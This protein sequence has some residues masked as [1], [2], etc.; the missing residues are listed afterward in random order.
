MVSSSV[1]RVN[2]ITFAYDMCPFHSNAFRCTLSIL[3]WDMRHT[4]RR[5]RQGPFVEQTLPNIRALGATRTR[6][7][8]ELRKQ[9]ACFIHHGHIG[10]LNNY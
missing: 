1:N 10:R 5:H 2:D 8:N 3:C 4:L 7:P 9:A 6:I